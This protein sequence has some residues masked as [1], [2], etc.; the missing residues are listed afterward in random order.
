MREFGQITPTVEK[1]LDPAN[2]ARFRR[3]AAAVNNRAVFEI[4]G[5]LSEIL[6]KT[7]S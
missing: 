5:M 6:K 4:P 2:F 3:N 7:A 1:F